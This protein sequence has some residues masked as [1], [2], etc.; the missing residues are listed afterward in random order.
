M[1]WHQLRDRVIGAMVYPVFVLSFGM[2]ATLFLM[3][4]VMPPL[5]LPDDYAVITPDSVES[6]GAGYVLKLKQT[7]TGRVKIDGKATCTTIR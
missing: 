5:G 3:T 1:R 2:A 7:M 4:F 6:E